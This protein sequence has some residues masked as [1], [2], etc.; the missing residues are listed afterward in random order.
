MCSRYQLSIDEV[1]WSAAREAVLDSSTSLGETID[2][3]SPGNNLPLVHVRFPYGTMLV[4]QGAMQFPHPQLNYQSVPLGIITQNSIEVFQETRTSLTSIAIHDQGLQLGVTAFMGWQG[5]EN[6]TAGARSLFLIPKAAQL[7]GYKR[8]RRHYQITTQPYKSLRDQWQ[9]F[10]DIANSA[11]LPKTWYTDVYFLTEPWFHLLRNDKAGETL[12]NHIQT[13]AFE[14]TA[15]LRYQQ[16]LQQLIATLIADSDL[17]IHLETI[18]TV[19]QLYLIGM[20]IVPGSVPAFH[21]Q[22]A[23]IIDLQNAYF[24]DYQIK[25]YHPSFMGPAYFTP[26]E[27]G[28]IYHSLAIN[29]QTKLSTV[30]LI[31]ELIELND[32]LL[33]AIQ[34]QIPVLP[35]QGCNEKGVVAIFP[36][37]YSRGE[38]RGNRS[39][40]RRVTEIHSPWP[41]FVQFH[42]YLFLT[43]RLLRHLHPRL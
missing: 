10:R 41:P 13:Q 12:L 36:I 19:I 34:K 21:D 27:S 29:T 14:K 2:Q 40:L 16:Y 42:S 39:R 26:G 15:Y 35:K 11:V 38:C 37:Y 7:N 8:L 33:E 20:G 17:T 25:P 43:S 18:N 4:D 30:E 23:P 1:N 32:F 5:N 22:H 24:N 31:R 28:S 3:L 9:V 6:V